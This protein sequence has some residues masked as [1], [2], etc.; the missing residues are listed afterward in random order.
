MNAADPLDLPLA[1]YLLVLGVAV[2]GGLVGYLN[3]SALERLSWGQALIV[4]FTSGFLGFL[5]FC[6]CLAKDWSMP[7]TLVT[8]GAIGLMGK[9]AIVD[10]QNIVRIRLGLLPAE[11]PNSERVN[12]EHS[13]S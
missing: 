9:R 8:V 4:A 11:Q 10:I 12:D 5:A 13:S 1:T 6:I 7:W 2:A 3:K